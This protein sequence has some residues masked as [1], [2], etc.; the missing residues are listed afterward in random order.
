MIRV[1]R[2]DHLVFTCRDVAASIAFYTRVLG[3]QEIT[4]GAGRKALGFGRQKINLQPMLPDSTESEIAAKAAIPTP[5]S[6]DLCLIVA[7]P[8]S[9]VVA[10]LSRLAVPVVEGP[11]RR[12]GATGP[13]VSV[14]IRDPD[15]N[16][17]ELSN[18]L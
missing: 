13:I 10:E 3:M 6:A 17:I 14:Y 9:E 15:G 4:F 16:L 18:P 8:L 5:G 7:T 11:I 1:D 2:F 12:T